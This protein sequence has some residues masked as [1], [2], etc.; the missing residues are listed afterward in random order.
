MDVRHIIT[1][2]IRKSILTTQGD[3]P[4]RGAAIPERLAA[5][6]AHTVL[7]GQGAGL[8]PAFNF[9]EGDAGKILMGKGGGVASAF[10]P[11][12]LDNGGFKGGVYIQDASGDVVFNAV[13]FEPSL[14]VFFAADVTLTNQNWSIIFWCPLA[15]GG[16][17]NS[18]Q[19][20]RTAVEGVQNI[21]IH[22]GAGNYLYG[23]VSAT[24]SSGFTVTHT[25][26]GVCS[27]HIYWFAIK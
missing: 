13:G 1:D 8:K 9:I 3:M 18:D 22:R 14:I 12:R 5:G 19:G 27:A 17:I 16:I 20:T 21:K 4:V 25:L 2:F 7:T 23:A 6:A 10:E 11:F 15:E 24:D 26:V